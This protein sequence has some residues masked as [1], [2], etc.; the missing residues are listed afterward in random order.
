MKHIIIFLSLS[1]TYETYSQSSDSL[2]R[3]IDD[4]DI[5]PKGINYTKDIDQK[6]IDNQYQDVEKFPEPIGGINGIQDKIRYPSKAIK[7]NVEGRVYILAFVDENGDV[8]NAMVLQG[9]GSGCD[10]E[11]LNAV[12]ET[13]FEPGIM[14][15][16]P[17][18]VQISI[19]IIFKLHP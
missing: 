13:K 6:E 2:K 16:K 4:I 15:G 3:S 11:A 7:N 19:P 5:K 10:E 14:N 1:L 18:K 8:T 12:K 9:I 17:S